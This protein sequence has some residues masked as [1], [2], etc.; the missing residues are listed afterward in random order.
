MTQDVVTLN[1]QLLHQGNRSLDIKIKKD[2]FIK[3]IQIIVSVMYVSLTKI[4]QSIRMYVVLKKSK[5]TS[6]SAI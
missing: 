4:H 3:L 5:F 2:D 6:L 1:V